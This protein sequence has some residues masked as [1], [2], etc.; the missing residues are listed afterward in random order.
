M[1]KDNLRKFISKE[2]WKNKELVKGLSKK[3]FDEV[4]KDLEGSN[5]HSEN[6][7]FLANRIGSDE[8]IAETENILHR[9]SKEGSLAYDLYTGRSQITSKLWKLLL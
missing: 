8:D 6:A 2:N 7:V 9:H 4:F 3:D 5:C 1:T